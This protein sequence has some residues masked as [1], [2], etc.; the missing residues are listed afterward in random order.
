MGANFDV[1]IRCLKG[2]G[3]AVEESL[4]VSL[5]LLTLP[6]DFDVLVTTL[7]T[8]GNENFKLNYVKSHLLEEEAKRVETPGTTLREEEASSARGNSNGRRNRGKGRWRGRGRGRGNNS[9]NKE[10]KTVSALSAQNSNTVFV[11]DSGASQ[12]FIKKE[13]RHLLQNIRSV[14]KLQVN[15]ASGRAIEFHEMSNGEGECVLRMCWGS[16]ITNLVNRWP[17]WYHFIRQVRLNCSKI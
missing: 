10:S 2:T 9:N 17:H 6:T 14:G 13:L 12:H 7:E 16:T 5:L 8:L 11:I 15:L 3:A 4:L 1:A